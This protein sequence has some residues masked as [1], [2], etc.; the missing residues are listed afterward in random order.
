VHS[1]EDVSAMQGAITGRRNA[2]T[3]DFT[4]V[5]GMHIPNSSRGIMYGTCVD[6]IR[7]LFCVRF[8]EMLLEFSRSVEYSSDLCIL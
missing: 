4:K 5:E 3:R 6:Y 1:V 2:L 7:T 8:V